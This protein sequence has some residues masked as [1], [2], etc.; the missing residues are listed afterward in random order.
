V[1][2]SLFPGAEQVDVEVYPRVTFIDCGENLERIACP[3]CEAQLSRGW[4]LDHMDLLGGGDGWEKANVDAALV[5]ACCGRHVTLRTLVYD[6]PVGFARFTVE[7]WEPD[8]WPADERPQMP[9]DALGAAI[10]V[11]MRGLW[12][13][14]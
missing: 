3:H 8:P 6:W 13:H 14:L 9:A 11:P 10:G 5:S 12:S 7:V 1:A 2:W 4:W